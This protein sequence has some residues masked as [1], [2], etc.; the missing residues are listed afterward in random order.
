ML[1]SNGYW[2]RDHADDEGI[3]NDGVYRT[4]WGVYPAGGAY[5]NG[6]GGSTLESINLG[7]AGIQP[8]I[9]ASYTHFWLA[10]AALTMGVNADARALLKAGIELSLAKVADFMVKQWMRPK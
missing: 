9:L 8:I 7:G 1:S 4:A 2:G 3:P 10:E 5:D 6:T